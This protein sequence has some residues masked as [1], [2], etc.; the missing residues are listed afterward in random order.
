MH[1]PPRI[2]VQAAMH[3]PPRIEVHANIHANPSDTN[4]ESNN[5]PRIIENKQDFQDSERNVNL[6]KKPNK[7]KK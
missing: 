1:T 3:A 2:E 6:I 7:K 5:I 4:H